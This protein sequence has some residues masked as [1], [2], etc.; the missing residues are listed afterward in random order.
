[1]DAHRDNPLK[2]NFY[3]KKK[4]NILTTFSNFHKS[5]VKTFL[6]IDY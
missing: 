2:E 5:D 4:I 6:K 1:M 3:K